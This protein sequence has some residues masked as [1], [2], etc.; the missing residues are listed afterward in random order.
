MT[1]KPAPSGPPAPL[2]GVRVLEVGGI[3]P[4]PF[5]GML[6]AEMGADVVRIDRPDPERVLPG[7][8]IDDLLS[9][10]KRSI[11]LDL[12]QADELEVLL[13]LTGR[14]DVLLEGFRPGV[15]ERLGFGPDACHER[16][17]ALVFGRMTGWGQEGPLAQ[18]AGHDLNYIGL[19]GA[20]HA[21]GAAGGP[22]QVP[23]NVIGDFGG[24]AMYLVVG[25]LAG[26]W[27]A[28]ATGH[29]RVVDAAIVDG[30]AHLLASVHSLMNAGAWRDER[31][32][33]LLDGGAPFYAVYE[34]ADER[35]MAV[36]AIEARFYRNLVAT[37]AVPLDPAAQN[38]RDTWPRAREVLA[39]AFRRRTRPAWTEAFADVDACVSPV[40]SLQEAVRD[41]HLLGRATLRADGGRVEAAAAPRFGLGDPPP[42]LRPPPRLGVHRADVVADWLGRV[43][44]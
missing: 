38:D 11:T 2:D 37:L 9:R 15:A 35:Y 7:E 8:I 42:G 17:A 6:L 21:I 24:G 32:T 34:T 30:T 25:V 28:R 19:T 39:G 20:L 31:G 5:A 41:P 10:G 12:K 23:L 22:P 29:G 1:A 40:L 27:D 14:A 4:V 36:A 16:N 18:R 43:P 44:T 3:G 33:N 26:L 13:A